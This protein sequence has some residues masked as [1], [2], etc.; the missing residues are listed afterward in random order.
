MHLNEVFGYAQTK[1]NLKVKVCLR[2]ALEPQPQDKSCRPV[3]L[4]PSI[5]PAI[6]H[7]FNFHHIH[8]TANGA[9]MT[10]STERPPKVCRLCLYRCAL[11]CLM[12]CLM[13]V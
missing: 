10:T 8:L 5:V 3:Y 4:Y 6:Q 12:L 9:Y 11:G 7:S 2:C 1:K 13:C